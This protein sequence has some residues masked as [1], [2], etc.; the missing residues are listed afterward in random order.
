LVLGAVLL[1]EA[2]VVEHG[3]HVQQLGV[4]LQ[5]APLPLQHPEQVDA[6]R[7]VEQQR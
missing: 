4:R 7:V 6:P 3:A 1:G 2:E 5:A